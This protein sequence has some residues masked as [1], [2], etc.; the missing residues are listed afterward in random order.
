MQ[1]EAIADPEVKVLTPD[2]I[3]DGLLPAGPTVVYD[4]DG[5]YMGGVIAEKLRA[6]GLEVTLVTPHNLVSVWAE[7]TGEGWREPGHLM[8]LGIGLI[9][10]HRLG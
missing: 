10:A 3:M 8:G 4:A 7:K 2:D 9:T 6:A 1:F 5:Y